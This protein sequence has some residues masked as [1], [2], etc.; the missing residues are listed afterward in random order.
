MEFNDKI[1]IYFQIKQYIC[2]E[3]V[4][5][6]LSEGS[7]LPTVRQLAVDLT[8]NVNTVQRALSELVNDK[9]IESKRGKGNFV[10]TDEQILVQLRRT[11]IEE[12]LSL[13]YDRLS[14]LQ[15]SPDEM[16]ESLSSYIEK[17]K[18]EHND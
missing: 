16:L 9:I 5:N 8:V 3:I 10:T 1:P 12:Q 11:M 7:Q 6:H 2:K 15:I 4:I 17:K 18:G 14:D 13:L